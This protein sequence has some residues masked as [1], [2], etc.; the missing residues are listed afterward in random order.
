MEKRRQLERERE[1]E[2][3]LELERQRVFEKEMER[4]REYIKELEK[5]R[6]LLK[7]IEKER[8]LAKSMEKE[9]GLLKEVDRERDTVELKKM[10]ELDAGNKVLQKLEHD[11]DRK[12]EKHDK[13]FGY[14]EETR[15][16]LEKDLQE[17]ERK[18]RD[19]KERHARELEAEREAHSIENEEQ[20]RQKAILL[21]KMR[22]IDEQKL[23]NDKEF[24]LTTPS[25]N[26]F[27]QREKQM[28]A[29]GNKNL[30]SFGDYKPS[31]LSENA[32]SK[33]SKTGLGTG[34]DTKTKTNKSNGDMFGN[35]SIIGLN[36]SSRN[37]QEHRFGL[38]V[39]KTEHQTKKV[40]GLGRKNLDEDVE[41]V[42]L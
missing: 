6:E 39:S 4:E 11:N 40:T 42:V 19:E 31:F 14:G 35:D 36:A 29:N 20:M 28:V 18:E 27:I 21:A 1:V 7:E 16:K 37:S 41:E 33:F 32:S 9:R 24:F 17:R 38:D 26:E 23:V 3:R 30:L 25:H 10:K 2:R 5:E 15:M 22:A 12:S 8:G 13:K 34:N